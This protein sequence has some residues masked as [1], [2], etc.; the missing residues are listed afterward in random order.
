MF[1]KPIEESFL[2]CALRKGLETRVLDGITSIGAQEWFSLAGIFVF[3]ALKIEGQGRRRSAQGSLRITANL[4]CSIDFPPATPERDV[5][6]SVALEAHNP[7][8]WDR[9]L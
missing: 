8:Y 7:S 4:S 5:Q 3:T 6:V 1:K 9:E 2:Q